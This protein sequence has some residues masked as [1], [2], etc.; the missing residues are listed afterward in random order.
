M[1]AESNPR[2]AAAINP[3][4]L[5]AARHN[6]ESNWARS[7]RRFRANRLALAAL[8]ITVLLVAMSAGAPLISR[9][10]THV[11]PDDQRLLDNLQGPSASHL[12]GTDEYG[13]D[14]F[15][16]IAYGG[17]VS[18]G[19]AFLGTAVALLV[20]TS[21]G[22]LAAYYGGWVDMVL[23][24]FVDVMLSIPA[25]FLLILLGSMFQLGP[26]TLA[27]T[28]ALLSWFGLARLIRAEVLSVKKRDYVD[29]ARV[30]GVSDWSI[31]T[32]H[33]LPNVLHIIIVVATLAVP[34]FI[35]TEAALSFLGFGVQPPTPSWGNMLTNAT[36]Y[37]YSSLSLIFIPG[38]F[39]SVTVLSL[40]IVGDA[41]RDALDPRLS[42]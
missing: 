29:A 30:V 15:T 2:I 10:I 41:L 1:E 25:I 11:N 5:R 40:S 16:R 27:I 7:W 8:C 33:I 18:M 37:F 22:A 38:L 19:V 3:A 42:Q 13:R 31:V 39:I 26:A 21:V 4:Q 35:L 32:R 28:I 14:V 9:Y 24:R 36:Q 34:G 23:M 12:L 20:G 17:R 6:G